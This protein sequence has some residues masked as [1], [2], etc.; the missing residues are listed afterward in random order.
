M[1]VPAGGWKVSDSYKAV[2]RVAG[3][4]VLALAL[5]LTLVMALAAC[6]GDDAADTTVGVTTTEAESTD[7]TVEEGVTMDPALVGKWHSV[8]GEQGGTLEFTS[9]GRMTATSD[10]PAEAVMEFTCVAEG[11]SIMLSVAG[12]EVPAVTYSIEGDVL[13]IVDPEA[14]APDIYQ[15]VA[16]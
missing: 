3:S 9:D 8:G 11:G 5:C 7:G 2:Y 6:G 1:V 16:E 4:V 13:T 12:E 10:D 14:E 15:R